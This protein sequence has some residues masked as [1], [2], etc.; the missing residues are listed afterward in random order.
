MGMEREGKIFNLQKLKKRRQFL[1]N[2]PPVPEARLWS[3]LKG[4]Q[5]NGYKFR[6]QHSID[7]YIVD[8]YC[9]EMKLAIEIDGDSHYFQDTQIRDK[10]RTEKIYRHGVC[11]IRFTNTEIMKNIEGVLGEI[12]RHCTTPNPSPKRRGDK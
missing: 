3:R 8:F 1:R 7:S 5:L 12:V 2:N 10:I 6:R 11:L 4:K 9:S